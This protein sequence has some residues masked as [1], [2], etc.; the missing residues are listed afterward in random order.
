MT[1]LIV[2]KWNVTGI[3]DSWCGCAV[4]SGDWETV[5]TLRFSSL[6]P[7]SP[8]RTHHRPQPGVQ[9]AMDPHLHTATTNGEAEQQFDDTAVFRVAEKI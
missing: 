3:F 2:N 1:P 9:S 8:R 4:E 7:P 6:V 5:S